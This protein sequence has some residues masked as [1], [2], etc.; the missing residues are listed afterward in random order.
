MRRIFAKI[1]ALAQNPRPKGCKKLRSRKNLWRVRIGDYRVVY[2]I[3]DKASM[4]DIIM[5]RHRDKVYE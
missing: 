2:T 4:I 5:V 1:E 3:D